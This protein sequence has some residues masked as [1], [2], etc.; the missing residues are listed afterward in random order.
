MSFNDMTDATD[1]SL[2]KLLHEYAYVSTIQK[3]HVPFKNHRSHNDIELCNLFQ[4][5]R[6][7]TVNRQLV[8]FNIWLVTLRIVYNV[9]TPS[10]KP[11]F[12]HYFVTKG[13]KIIL[14]NELVQVNF[15]IAFAFALALILLME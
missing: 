11:C 9:R 8:N 3:F 5:T 1:A 2:H 7:F 15:I 6:F 4:E 13:N 14:H 10:Y 12:L